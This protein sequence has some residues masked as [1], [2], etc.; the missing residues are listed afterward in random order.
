MRRKCSSMT[1]SPGGRWTL[2]GVWDLYA[3]RVVPYWVADTLPWGISHAWVDEKDRDD[4]MTPINGYEWPVPMPKD[5]NLD[6]LRIEMLNLGAE[7][8]W[9]DVLCL[10][11]GGWEER[12]SAHGGVEA[13]RAHNRMGVC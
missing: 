7:Y 10:P 13:R 9:L 11:A 2:D 3:N 6:L 8:T 12:A 5:A 1:G 4:A